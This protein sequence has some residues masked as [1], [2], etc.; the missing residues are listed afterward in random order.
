MTATHIVIESKLGRDAH[1]RHF[2][3]CWCRIFWNVLL[4]FGN[5]RLLSI[6]SVNLLVCYIHIIPDLR[7][8]VKHLAFP[9]FLSILA[10]FLVEFLW[11]RDT[12]EVSWQVGRAEV[13]K[14]LFSW[15][16][17]VIKLG[18]VNWRI[19]S[20][21]LEK[22]GLHLVNRLAIWLDIRNLTIVVWKSKSLKNGI[23]FQKIMS[24]S[25]WW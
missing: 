5:L 8:L 3:S 20:L 16:L 23:L 9:H 24:K 13:L 17:F 18:I 21:P 14:T 2:V 25:L 22:V 7:N 11:V 4:W 19:K 15:I 12:G 1:S 6:V 10:Q